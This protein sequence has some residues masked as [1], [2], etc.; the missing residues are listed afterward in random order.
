LLIACAHNKKLGHILIYRTVRE[1]NREVFGDSDNGL[2]LWLNDVCEG[3]QQLRLSSFGIGAENI[4][5][6][7]KMAFTAGRMDNNPVDISEEQVIEI[8]NNII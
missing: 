2:E 4:E 6:I 5:P 1:D 8:L 3:I 7:A